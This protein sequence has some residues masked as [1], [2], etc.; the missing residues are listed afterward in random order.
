VD[1]GFRRGTR[2]VSIQ[3]AQGIRQPGAHRGN[4][5][6]TTLVRSRLRLATVAVFTIEDGAGERGPRRRVTAGDDVLPLLADR[7]G[8]E[9]TPPGAD[10]L[11][12]RIPHL[13]KPGRTLG[14]V[15]DVG[16]LMLRAGSVPGLGRT[17]HVADENQVK[18]RLHAAAAGPLVGGALGR[19]DEGDRCLTCLR[20]DE[21][22]GA[23]YAGDRDH[24]VDLVEDGEI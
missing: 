7:P 18:V 24:L 12:R 6:S 1:R 15:A 3:Q 13:E 22:N 5:R 21:L 8:V 14:V 23:A 11:S 17:V 16:N 19:D 10:A 2:T 4:I 9:R 20:S